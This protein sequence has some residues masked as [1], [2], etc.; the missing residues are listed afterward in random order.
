MRMVKVPTSELT[1]S[2]LNWAVAKIEDPGLAWDEDIE[3]FMFSM[4]HRFCFLREFEPSTEWGQ[5]GPILGDKKISLEYRLTADE[6]PDWWASLDPYSPDCSEDRVGFAGPTPLIAA[7][8]C[9]VASKYG[10]EVEIPKCLTAQG[11]S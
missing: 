11:K 5:G 8:R 7:M 9:L 6:V 2:A 4:R 3:D 10:D 1:C